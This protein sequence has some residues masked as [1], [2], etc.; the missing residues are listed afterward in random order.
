MS[1]RSSRSL[2]LLGRLRIFVQPMA[3]AFAAAVL[4]I[5]PVMLAAYV[6]VTRPF[7]HKHD[8]SDINAGAAIGFMCGIFP[9]FLNYPS[10]LAEASGRPKLR[11]FEPGAP[12]AQAAAGEATAAA[13]GKATPREVSLDF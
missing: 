5:V 8:F 10:I 9:Y 1:L 3:G 12:L 11:S 13:G 6:A 4:C 7:N 2:Y